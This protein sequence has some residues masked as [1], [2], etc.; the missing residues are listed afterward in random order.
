MTTLHP[1]N[2]ARFYIILDTSIQT[3]FTRGDQPIT[4]TLSSGTKFPS[5]LSVLMKKT[6]RYFSTTSS[7]IEG[8][9]EP[10]CEGD[11]CECVYCP[12]DGCRNEDC[13]EKTTSST[14]FQCNK[15]TCTRT[16]NMK[17][18]MTPL[19]P[20]TDLYLSEYNP[21]FRFVKYVP[22]QKIEKRHMDDIM[23]KYLNENENPVPQ[24]KNQIFQ[25]PKGW[26]L[27]AEMT[28]PPGD[29]IPYVGTV[30]PGE[31]PP[32]GWKVLPGM[33]IP[34]GGT[35]PPNFMTNYGKPPSLSLN[36]NI[37]PNW[38]PPPGWKVLPRMIIP[39]GGTSLPNFMTNYG[40][41]P[42]LSLNQNIPPDWTPPPGITMPPSGRFIPYVGTVPPGETPPPGWKVFPGM[43]IPPDEIPNNIQNVQEEPTEIQLSEF[44]V[45]SITYPSMSDFNTSEK[46]LKLYQSIIPF[47][48]GFLYLKE[49]RFL[50]HNIAVLQQILRKNRL[51]KTLLDPKKINMRNNRNGLQSVESDAVVIERYDDTQLNN[52]TVPSSSQEDT[53]ETSEDLITPEPDEYIEKIEEAVVSSIN[54]VETTSTPPP[55]STRLP[56]VKQKSIKKTTKKGLSAGTKVGIAVG[57][58]A[59]VVIVVYGVYSWKKKKQQPR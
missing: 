54:S 46:F 15:E 5:D 50:Q 37:S 35:F 22:S 57:V 7:L 55:T 19:Y 23:K 31:T 59:A 14:S 52:I 33:V 1:Q 21:K 44:V 49:E 24:I 17:Y 43:I 42:S 20:A 53:D 40:E 45:F 16:N 30:P 18:Y 56:T 12:P 26:R 58:I 38:T 36:Q 8:V 3:M 41:P 4:F 13:L 51:P 47:N 11:E 9:S 34:P 32:P 29:F 2:K 48:L 10:K 27:P 28:I 25:T 39:T 6:G